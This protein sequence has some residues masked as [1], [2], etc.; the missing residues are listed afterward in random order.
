MARAASLVS[1]LIFQ[2]VDTF[3]KNEPIFRRKNAIPFQLGSRLEI[4]W[5]LSLS[6]PTVP[7]LDFIHTEMF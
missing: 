1:K 7:G 3:K 2:C 4:P 5:A 6:I